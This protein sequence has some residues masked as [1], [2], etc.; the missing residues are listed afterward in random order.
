MCSFL[1]RVSREIPVEWQNNMGERTKDKAAA[2]ATAR[3]F[4]ASADVVSCIIDLANPIF[5]IYTIFR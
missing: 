5:E 1:S 3:K 2:A 4:G